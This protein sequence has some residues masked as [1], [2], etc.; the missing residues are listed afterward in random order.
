MNFCV[1]EDSYHVYLS[2]DAAGTNRNR[3]TNT[4]GRAD[5]SCMI[6]RH[7]EVTLDESCDGSSTGIGSWR[8]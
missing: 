7:G 2:S 4:S 3:L 1:A 5:S 8:F 6:P